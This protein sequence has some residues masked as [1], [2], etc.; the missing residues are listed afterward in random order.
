MGSPDSWNEAEVEVSLAALLATLIA[1][2]AL[3]VLVL[4]VIE[5]RILGRCP[6]PGG[7][8][9]TPLRT[10]LPGRGRP[11]ASGRATAPDSS[12]KEIAMKRSP[13]AP[14]AGAVLDVPRSPSS[15]RTRATAQ[16]RPQGRDRFFL[17]SSSRIRDPEFRSSFLPKESRNP[18]CAVRDA[19][20][21]SQK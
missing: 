6:R 15:T 9:L 17:T 5:P 13:L 10:I 11:L 20:A 16:K 4:P 7:P 3:V 14:V 12:S 18:A 2:A 21:R 19:R 1:V 8:A